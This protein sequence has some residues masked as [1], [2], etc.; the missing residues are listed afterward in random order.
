[1]GGFDDD[2]MRYA[3]AFKVVS[4]YPQYLITDKYKKLIEEM[5]KQILINS[6]ISFGIVFFLLIVGLVVI[7]RF[8]SK[9]VAHLNETIEVADKVERGEA[10]FRDKDDANKNMNYEILQT[11]NALFDLG[12]VFNSTNDDGAVAASKEDDNGEDKNV[13]KYA[14]KIKLFGMLNDKRMIGVLHN[15]LGNLHFRAGRYQEAVD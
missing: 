9:I 8:A 7:M 11:K 14:F 12:N 5:D 13:L 4:I 10:M 2:T 6:I 3:E 15:N 1:M